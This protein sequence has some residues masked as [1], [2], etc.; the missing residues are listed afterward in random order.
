MITPTAVEGVP[1][2]TG[3]LIADRYVVERELGSGAFSVVF[4]CDDIKCGRRVALKILSA[5]SVAASAFDR[6]RHEITMLANL[7]HP[8]LM[9]LFDCGDIGEL[10]YYVMP[11]VDGETLRARLERQ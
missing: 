11:Y 6:F 2:S 10:P 1:V 5:S 7:Q 3:D 8:N 9:P 4:L